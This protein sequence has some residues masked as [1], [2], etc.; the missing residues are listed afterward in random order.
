M[1]ERIPID[2]I[3]MPDI[4]IDAAI[5]ARALDVDITTFREL[6]ERQ[7]IA[8]LCQRGTGADSGRYRAT[9]YLDRRR[10][11]LV[12]DRDGRLCAPLEQGTLS[13]RI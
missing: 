3:A 4:E 8:M 2:V 10:V 9:F 5:V 1:G 6:M 7:R 13:A 11:R 12:V